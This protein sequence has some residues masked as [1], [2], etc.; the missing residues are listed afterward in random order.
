MFMITFSL[1]IGQCVDQNLLGRYS[2]SVFIKGAFW[3][4]ADVLFGSLCSSAS[5]RRVW[6]MFRFADEW[7]TS[8][9][10]LDSSSHFVFCSFKSKV[11]TSQRFIR[12]VSKQLSKDCFLI[13]PKFG[14][15]VI[16][17]PSYF[18]IISDVFF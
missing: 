16:S 3:I 14:F 10:T 4:M 9:Q 8:F 17:W 18:K 13:S 6:F 11:V 7:L 15:I 5:T 1:D 2:V 12:H